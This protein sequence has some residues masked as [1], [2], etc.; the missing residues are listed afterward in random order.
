MISLTQL[1][2][3]PEELYH[4]L[5]GTLLEDA[6]G[7]DHPNT[8]LEKQIADLLTVLT[9]QEWIDFSQPKNQVVAKYFDSKDN[10]RKTRFFHQLLLGVELY[11]RIHLEG[12][13][14]EAKR[15][16]LAALPPK[17]SWDLALAERWQDNMTI[18]K[19]RTSSSESVFSFQ[20]GNK[21]KQKEALQHF[22][23]LLKWP[24]MQEL[25]YVLEEKGRYEVPLEDRSADAMSWFAGVILP[26]PTLPWLLMNS[27][28]DC[29]KETGPSLK[30][31]THVVP[32]SGFQYRAN[33]YWSY[34]CIV[35]KVLGAS[36]GVKQVTGWIGPCYYSP[37]LKRTE[38][39]KINQVSPPKIRLKPKDVESMK[40]RT[41]P[42]GPEEDE[43]PLGDYDLVGPEMEDVT[44]DIRVQ[45]LSFHPVKEQPVAKHGGDTAPLLFD[46]SIMF[47]C[48]GDSWPM[49]LTYDVD[50]V[51]AYPCHQGPHGK[52]LT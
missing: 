15:A 19:S 28:I 44:D 16:L 22:A 30:Y 49:R 5:Y 17:V 25:D 42:L 29:D 47:A 26:G 38:C 1:A 14:K 11:M 24:N 6:E 45:K 43:Y 2:Q 18:K 37:D 46:A 52:Q 33:T 48:G 10:A 20:L 9:N 39:V 35:G 50:F 3:D 51:A 13:A 23:K 41:D 27:L 32:A 7:G 31:L 21:K 40:I 12:H 8:G 36:R 34:K 4:D